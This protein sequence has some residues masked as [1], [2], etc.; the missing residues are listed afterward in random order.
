LSGGAGIA[1]S[2]LEVFRSGRRILNVGSLEIGAGEFVNV[3]G[4]N[5]A[6][7]TTLVNVLCGLQR[8]TRGR[9]LIGGFSMFESVPWR[10]SNA[11]KRIGYIPQSAEY[12]RELPFTVR[13]VAAMGRASVKPLLCGLN[14]EDYRIADEWVE[15]VGLGGQKG[16]T[17]PSLSGGEQQ[18]VLIARAMCQGPSL[19]VLDEPASNLDFHWK[20]RLGRFIREL[21][22]ELGISVVMISHELA[23]I[24]LDTDRCIVLDGGDILAD[25][26]TEAVLT[27]EIIEE[28]YHCR[29]EVCEIGGRR[30]LINYDLADV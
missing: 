3:I 5:G 18:K 7:K 1:I 8:P 10:R 29:I 2:G 22:S 12:N 28:L 17:F 13:E 24:P 20:Q 11:R 25:G 6:G 30:H 14:D 9:V 16:Q 27:S 21:N 26:G 4:T 19:L 23:S 15:K